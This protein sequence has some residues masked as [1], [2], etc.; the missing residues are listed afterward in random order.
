MNRWLADPLCTVVSLEAMESYFDPYANAFRNSPGILND[1]E[2]AWAID[3]SD[4][5]VFG[6]R[7]QQL[8]C[9]QWERDRPL[10][11]KIASVRKRLLDAD[12]L[13]FRTPELGKRGQGASKF[14]YDRSETI[15]I[16]CGS[17]REHALHVK[18]PPTS[19]RGADSQGA[20]GRQS[21]GRVSTMRRQSA[22]E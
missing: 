22:R 21:K 17:Y 16:S 4:V 12:R 5:D 15:H 10:R 14:E 20:R 6:P 13:G 7:L 8:L 3:P 18:G 19:S 2:G 1:P 11:D 9:E